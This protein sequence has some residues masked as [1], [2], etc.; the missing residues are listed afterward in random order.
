MKGHIGFWVATWFLI[1]LVVPFVL[2]TE[3]QLKRIRTEVDDVTVAFGP[4]K[5][6]DL[7]DSASALYSAIF[8]QTGLLSQENKLYAKPAE[9]RVKT[10]PGAN[11]ANALT[12]ATNSYFVAFSMNIY[13]VLLR[14]GITWHWAVFILPFLAAAFVDGFVIRKVKLSEFG[15]IS[16]MAYSLSLHSVIFLLAI[17]FVYLVVPLPLTAYFMPMWALA[18]AVPVMLM[19][20][21]TQRLLKA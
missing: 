18:V 2:G 4:A 5:T 3:Q 13:G 8:V 12:T 15:Y 11:G 17:P 6:K 21:N 10:M 19:V 20:A 14:W 1:L 7:V 16:P 9:D